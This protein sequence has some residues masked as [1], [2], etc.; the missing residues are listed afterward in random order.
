MGPDP[1]PSCRG[2]VLPIEDS[3]EA[4]TLHRLIA[5]YFPELLTSLNLPDAGSPGLFTLF[6]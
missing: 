2:A 1:S 5:I 4:A 3:F 6:L